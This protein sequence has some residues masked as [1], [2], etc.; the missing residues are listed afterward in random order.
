MDLEIA[1]L[2]RRVEG[3]A[4]E[5]TEGPQ[6]PQGETGPAGPAGEDGAD[7]ANAVSAAVKATGNLSSVSFSNTENPL[8]WN[9]PVIQTGSAT[10]DIS[11]SGNTVTINTTGVY[12]FSVSL[13][14]SNNNRTEL[15]IRTYINGV[16]DTSELVSNYVSRDSDQN[17][18]GIV[19]VTSLFLTATDTVQFRGFGDCDGTCTGLDDGT[20][21][22]I[23]R[24]S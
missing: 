14:T 21:L 4:G 15:F 22:L 9:S 23:E 24:L 1:R 20:R 16:E 13:R 12:K 8:V 10:T 17:T 18:G 2:L 7:G 11:V 3:M 5:G 19:L 6:G